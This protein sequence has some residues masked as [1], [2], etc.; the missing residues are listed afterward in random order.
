MIVTNNIFQWQCLIVHCFIIST[1]WTYIILFQSQNNLD[2]PF[3]DEESE[4]Q[5]LSDLLKSPQLQITEKGLK[6]KVF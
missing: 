3:V 1:Y 5:S 2:I 4:A 6:S